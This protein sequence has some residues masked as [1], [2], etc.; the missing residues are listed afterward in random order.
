MVELVYDKGKRQRK[1]LLC[2]EWNELNKK[3][4]L[5]LA[6]IVHAKLPIEVAKQRIT[7]AISNL[8]TA[9]YLLLPLQFRYHAEAYADW[10]LSKENS[11]TVQLLPRVTNGLL[12][13]TLWGPETDFGNLTLVEFHYTET[14]YHQLIHDKNADALDEL[15][16][17]MY[18]PGKEYYNHGRNREGDHRIAFLPGDISYVKSIVSQ[19]PNDYK[20]AVLLWYDGCRNELIKNYNIVYPEG[21]KMKSKNLFDG[22]YK[23]MRTL[24]GD[25]YG[26][27]DKVEQ[28]NIHTAHLEITCM[29]E[30]AERI[31][32]A[33][34]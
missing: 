7:Q 32:Q 4:L 2:S 29:Y 27:I 22:L 26:T 30:D 15:I 21:K 31:K 33:S 25:K 11:L 16:A 1:L 13:T 6:I 19:W 24:S 3:Q 17:V 18:R 28:I 23:M 5:K 12:G 8:C 10:V 14:A 34:K 9:K 20:L